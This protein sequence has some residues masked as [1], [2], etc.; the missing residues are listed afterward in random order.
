M[1]ACF[2]V[3]LSLL[4]APSTFA[5]R[6]YTEKQVI[7]YA[8]SIDVH[9]LDTSL[10]SQRLEDWLQSGPPHAHISG[11]LMEGTCQLK[12]D[13]PKVDYPLCVKVSL[14]R[15]G[16]F[17]EFLVQVGTSR[18]GIVGSPKLYSGVG[19]YEPGYT[20]IRSSE[21]LSDLPALLTPR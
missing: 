9:A 3:M 12:P 14:G 4:V 1:K 2:L 20:K 8:K 19:V 13:D 21:R 10:P 7:E 11:W 6:P 5:Q 16:A 17:G 15:D 18:S